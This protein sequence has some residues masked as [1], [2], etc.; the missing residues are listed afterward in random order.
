MTNYPTKTPR[1]VRKCS[2]CRE[3]GHDRRKCDIL[4]LH[5]T[6]F[7][8]LNSRFLHL[9][10]DDI[11]QKGIGPGALVEYIQ[12]VNG[13]KKAT[14]LAIVTEF[15]WRQ[16]FFRRPGKRWIKVHIL[17]KSQVSAGPYL[18]RG[19][20]SAYI[21]LPHH[22]LQKEWSSE[23]SKLMYRETLREITE[24]EMLEMSGPRYGGYWRLASPVRVSYSQLLKNRPV[25]FMHGWYGVKDHFSDLTKEGGVRECKSI[26]Q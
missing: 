9:V 2:Y 6:K 16:L 21:R 7:A 19:S 25:D 22:E 1:K 10:Q 14:M 11:E 18:H 26:T 23:N 5:S 17:D 24:S 20:Q 15:V 12:V 4:L 8:R 13:K 3:P